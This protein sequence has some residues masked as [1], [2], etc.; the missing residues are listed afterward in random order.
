MRSWISVLQNHVVATNY[1]FIITDN[2][3]TKWASI[4]TINSSVC[5]F[6]CLRQKFVV[7]VL[8]SFLMASK[9]RS[10]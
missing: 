1:N 7:P 5:F 10:N 2:N 9:C 6:N 4:A 8:Y 3:C